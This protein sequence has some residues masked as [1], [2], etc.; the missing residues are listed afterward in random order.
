MWFMLIVGSGW[1][2]YFGKHEL[3][4]QMHNEHNSANHKNNFVDPITQVCT[5][6][7]ECDWENVKWKV[8]AMMGAGTNNHGWFPSGWVCLTRNI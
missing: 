4:V 7:V 2:A 8:K 1:A 5:N 3:N 6:N